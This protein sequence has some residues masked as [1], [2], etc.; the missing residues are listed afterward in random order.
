[1]VSFSEASLSNQTQTHEAQ[2]PLVIE[3]PDLVDTIQ[4]SVARQI[5]LP[6]ALEASS[7]DT[8]LITL[9]NEERHEVIC[10]IGQQFD[11]A[12][13]NFVMATMINRR[14]RSLIIV[15]DKSEGIDGYLPWQ[16]PLKQRIAT[17]EASNT[18]TG[19][20]VSVERPSK[21][22]E[23]ASELSKYALSQTLELVG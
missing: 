13:I 23:T 10:Q 18:L 19:L 1:M 3:Y 7:L 2:Q 5:G 17:V 21:V 6:G 20:N 14:N 9:S 12:L 8:V 22:D 16:E 15:A 11:E 4:L